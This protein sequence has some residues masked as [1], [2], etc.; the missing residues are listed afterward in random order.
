MSVEL[1][2]HFKKKQKHHI[3]VLVSKTKIYLV[4]ELAAGGELVL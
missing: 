3:D 4:S 1:T 2:Y